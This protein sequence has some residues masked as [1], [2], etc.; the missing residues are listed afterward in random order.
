MGKIIDLTHQQFGR[1]YVEE[2]AKRNSPNGNTRWVC[3]CRC[4]NRIEAD[5]YSLRKGITRSCGCLRR[6]ISRQAALHNK[7]FIASQGSPL[8]TKEGIS[9]SSIVRGKRNQ[10]GVIGVSKD[11]KSG[12]YVARLMVKGHYV[13]NRT[14][15]DFD[16]AVRLRKQAEVEYFHHEFSEQLNES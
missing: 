2:K 1:L 3:L 16:E 13:L 6:E 5:G 11:E 8:M 15:P 14:T 4:G 9:Y 7:A 10:T 12:K